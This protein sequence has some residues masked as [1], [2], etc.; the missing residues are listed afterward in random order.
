MDGDL[1]DRVLNFWYPLMFFTALYLDLING[2]IS[3]VSADKKI[4]SVFLYAGGNE[5]DHEAIALA[6]RKILRRYS[7]TVMLIMIPLAR[8]FFGM[9]LQTERVL[10]LF[11]N[12]W[13]L[14]M[15]WNVAGLN[16]NCLGGVLNMIACVANGGRMPT[17]H[18]PPEDDLR[19]QIMDSETN[20][21]FLSDWIMYDYNQLSIGDFL[22][23]A[24]A[25]IFFTYQ[26]RRFFKIIINRN[27]I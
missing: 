16:I 25:F 8:I 27:R 20:L 2:C 10:Y 13:L 7:P 17:L 14:L 24:G 22:I 4:F 11:F 26:A 9:E 15:N 12:L 3:A 6:F 18:A 23:A 1:V 19:H 5:A 21:G